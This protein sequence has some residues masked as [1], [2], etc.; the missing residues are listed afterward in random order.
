VFDATH[1][2]LLVAFETIGLYKVPLQPSLGAFVEIGVDQ[3]IEP[4]ISF[5]RPYNATP[6]D[7][8]FECEYDPEGD[9]MPGGVVAPG[10]DANAGIFLEAD[11][12]GL[13]IVDSI[14]GGTLLLASS[15]GDSSFHF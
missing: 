1:D 2:T 10:S 8:E 15:Q 12:E 3:L 11:L 6:D 7:D 5:G 9:Q 13:T 4:V 14:P